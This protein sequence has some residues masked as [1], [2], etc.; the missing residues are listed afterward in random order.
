MA[1]SAVEGAATA[2]ESL[3]LRLSENIQGN[4]L[5]PFNKPC[6]RFL[7]FSFMNRPQQARDWLGQLVRDGVAST[8]D[9]V[10]HNKAYVQAKK[11]GSTLPTHEWVGVSF[12][13]SGLVTLDPG[14]ARD[15]V[16]YDAFWQGPLV[17]RLYR[18]QRMMSPA[19]VGDVRLGDPRG[20]VVGGPGQYPVDAGGTIASDD[21][22]GLEACTDSVQKRQTSGSRCCHGRTADAGTRVR[23]RRGSSRSAS[24][25]ASRS[26]GSAVSPRRR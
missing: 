10:T 22:N 13:S 17:D 16:A 14:L 6:Q 3:P 8:S 7:F 11:D 1:E 15:L 24:G 18:E 2:G 21:E 25:T 4:I 9:V 5:E 20:W 26:P 12:T 23:T 19:V